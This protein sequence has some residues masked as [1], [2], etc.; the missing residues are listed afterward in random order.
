MLIEATNHIVCELKKGGGGESRVGQRMVA[1]FWKQKAFQNFGHEGEKGEWPI[2]GAKVCGF[3]GFEEGDD[4]C[5][6]PDSWNV[7][8]SV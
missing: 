2:T 7:C 3:S 1:K 4:D 6:L 8:M 5:R